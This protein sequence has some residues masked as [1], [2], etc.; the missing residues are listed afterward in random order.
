MTE[1]N[2]SVASYNQQ[3]QKN[4]TLSFCYGVVDIEPEN[5]KDISELLIESD[6]M[7]YGQKRCNNLQVS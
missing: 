1:L 2:E 7:M 3:N 6:L 4:Y 5:Q